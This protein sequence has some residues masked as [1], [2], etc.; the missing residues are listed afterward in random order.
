MRRRTPGVVPAHE[1]VDAAARELDRRDPR[2]VVAALEPLVTPE[3]RAR[4]LGVFERRTAAVTVLMDS[5]HDPHNGAAVIRSCD[6]FGVPRMHVVERLEPFVVATTVARGS[7]KWVEVELHAEA[8]SA[9][10]AL[11]RSGHE[12][13]ATSA[14]GELVPD[15]LASIPRV[16]IV[17]GNEREGIEP[18]LRA[19]CTR[20]VRVPMRGFAESLNVSV[21]CAILLSHAT[22]GRTGDLPDDERLR[23]YARGLFLSLPHA[24]DV[25]GAR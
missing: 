12:L 9:A 19:H 25:L 23:L 13:V 20:S 17:L 7:Q 5:P 15:D 21:T 10:R 8:A 3:R 24:A 11:A 1:L 4:L 6:A 22:T 14:D 2:E 16:A 18:A